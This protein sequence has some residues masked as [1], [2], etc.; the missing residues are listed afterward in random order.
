MQHKST[1]LLHL[2]TFH[3]RLYCMH[4]YL[5]S[6]F[7]CI[8]A[9]L[10]SFTTHEKTTNDSGCWVLLVAVGK[11]IN[12]LV[13]AKL[14]LPLAFGSFITALRASSV[15]QILLLRHERHLQE[16]SRH[17]IRQGHFI[18]GCISWE[19]MVLG[20]Y[21]NVFLLSAFSMLFSSNR[22]L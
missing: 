16:D 7:L 15:H 4:I 17:S 20:A 14:P 13:S 12:V 10:I 21:Q 11:R 19:K 2:H 5:R 6:F 3:H 22:R 8:G 18:L 1:R 9:T